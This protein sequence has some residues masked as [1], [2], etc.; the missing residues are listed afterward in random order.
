[1]LNAGCS[2]ATPGRRAQLNSV[3]WEIIPGAIGWYRGFSLPAGRFDHRLFAGDDLTV[4][5]LD[6]FDVLASLTTHLG[7]VFF[8]EIG[9]AG[10]VVF[11]G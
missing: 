11:D 7:T 9:V 6:K 1:M 4:F 2:G 10:I 8:G 3:C 5:G